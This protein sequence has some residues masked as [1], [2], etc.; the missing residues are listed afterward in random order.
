MNNKEF[1]K[2]VNETFDECKKLLT[3]KSRFYGQDQDRLAQLKQIGVAAGQ[4]PYVTTHTLVS[5]H[6]VALGDMV[7]RPGAYSDADYDAYLLDIIN[8]MVLLRA[9]MNEDH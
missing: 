4:S 9:L 3:E 7:K 6:F 1:M 5:K 2:I 8:Y